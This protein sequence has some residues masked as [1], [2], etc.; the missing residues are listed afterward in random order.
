MCKF[1]EVSRKISVTHTTQMKIIQTRNRLCAFLRRCRTSGMPDFS[2]AINLIND[3]VFLKAVYSS[4][5][6]QKIS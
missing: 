1:M 2:S 3:G 4:S 5:T 6:D